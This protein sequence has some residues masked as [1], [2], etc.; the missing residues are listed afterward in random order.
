MIQPG[1]LALGSSPLTRGALDGCESDD[2][3]DGLI[4]A[5]AGS[6][7]GVVRVYI[8]YPAHPRSRGEHCPSGC[9]RGCGRG[10]SPLTRG[11][12]RDYPARRRTVGLIPA[13]AGSTGWRGRCR[14]LSWAHPRSRGEH[15][16]Q[17][18]QKAQE[19]GSSPLTRGAQVKNTLTGTVLGLI[20]A[21]AGS[22]CAHDRGGCGAA[23]HPRSRGEHTC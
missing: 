15:N 23:A 10:S 17:T 13:H 4:P 8:M 7:F 14:P 2:V 5:H 11:A 3:D 22:T 19:M 1:Y 21:H 6:T 16:P 18:A 20:P 12:P 9:G